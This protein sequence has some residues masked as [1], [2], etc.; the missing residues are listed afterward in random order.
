M[1]FMQAQTKSSVNKNGDI[2][3]WHINDREQ[4]KVKGTINM[5]DEMKD[6]A[7]MLLPSIIIKF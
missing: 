6:Y 2:R 7:S 5:I 1:Q 4:I 3:G